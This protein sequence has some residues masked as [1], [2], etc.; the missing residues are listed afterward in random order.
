MDT[1]FLFPIVVPILLEDPLLM[2]AFAAYVCTGIYVLLR[3]RTKR[4]YFVRHGRTVL[5]AKHIRQ[6]A[7][8]GLDDVG[9]HQAHTVGAYL[10]NR[11]IKKMISSPYERTRETAAIMNTYLNVPISYS[12]LLRERKNPSEIIGKS[13]DDP[14]VETIVDQ[15]DLSYHTDAYRYSDEENF[16]DLKKRARACLS[17]LAR[18]H[19]RNTCVVTHN[20]FLKMLLSYILYREGLHAPAYVKLSF[21]NPADN[22]G[23]TICEYRPWKRWFTKARGWSVITYNETLDEIRAT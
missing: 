12:P 17:F 1:I 19:S 23:I 3:L 18:V 8:G 16:T 2:G 13:G 7:D 20:V 5:N 9:R 15:M 22:G 11:S 21:F 10:Q 4:Y 6:G 14:A